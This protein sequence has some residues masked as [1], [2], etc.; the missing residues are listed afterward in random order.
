MFLTALS[1]LT[2]SL[3][4]LVVHIGRS[5]LLVLRRV[6]TVLS[7]SFHAATSCNLLT[8]HLKP[9]SF[10]SQWA[11]YYITLNELLLDLRGRGGHHACSD[12]VLSL[13]H[14]AVAHDEGVVICK[15][16][17]LCLT[18]H[19]VTYILNFL[20]SAVCIMLSMKHIGITL[21][22]SEWFYELSLHASPNNPFLL[23]RDKRVNSSKL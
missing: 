10:R 3:S 4:R 1:W 8:F 13:I 22:A 2:N 17:I 16:Y 12:V 11:L 21:E 19:V 14:E 7:S 23:S 15:F 20:I 18:V 9:P 6:W 5:L